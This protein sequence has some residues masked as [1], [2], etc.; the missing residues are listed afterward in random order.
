MTGVAHNE[1]QR[2][3][4]RDWAWREKRDNRM[5]VQLQPL[6]IS[7]VKPLREITLLVTGEL[8]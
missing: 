2:K 3:T 6:L 4:M 8:M 1:P 5:P 7:D